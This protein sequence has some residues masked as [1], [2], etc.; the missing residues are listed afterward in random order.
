[1]DYFHLDPSARLLLSGTVNRPNAA[2]EKAGFAPVR[3][4]LEEDVV[5]CHGLAEDGS[6][7]WLTS[8]KV[9]RNPR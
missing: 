9:E 5:G 8:G 7:G 2:A 6:W 3:A 4:R 1:M